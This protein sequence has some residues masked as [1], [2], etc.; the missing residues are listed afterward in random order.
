MKIKKTELWMLVIEPMGPTHPYRW[1]KGSIGPQ[2]IPKYLVEH[3]FTVFFGEKKNYRDCFGIL[4]N[5]E[6]EFCFSRESYIEELKV[7]QI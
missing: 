3:D 2:T 5:S 4:R 6:S 1:S 7:G